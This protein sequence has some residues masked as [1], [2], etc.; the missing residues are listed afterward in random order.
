MFTA[1]L[2]D[3]LTALCVIVDNQLE[4][5]MEHQTGNRDYAGVYSYSFAGYK[6][7]LSIN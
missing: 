5:K 3:H 7:Y 4:K 6:L 1:E 2:R